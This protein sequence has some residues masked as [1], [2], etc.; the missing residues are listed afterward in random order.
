MT[1]KYLSKKSL[2][3]VLTIHGNRASRSMATGPTTKADSDWKTAK[4]MIQKLSDIVSKGG[5]LLLNVGP[6]GEGLIPPPSVERLSEIGDLLEVN[7]EAIYGCDPTPFGVEL[8]R[9]KKEENGKTKNRR[10]AS[11]ASHH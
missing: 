5:N 6:T 11:M 4:S 1:T 3:M 10:Q 9:K 2:R 7:G 8:G